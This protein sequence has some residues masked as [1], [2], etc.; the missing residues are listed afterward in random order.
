M[1]NP[2][3]YYQVYL[4]FHC[5]QAYQVILFSNP[6]YLVNNKL[7]EGD[8]EYDSNVRSDY[9]NLFAERM[10]QNEAFKNMKT[11]EID[12]CI[13]NSEAKCIIYQDESLYETSKS[14]N[15]KSIIK[16]ELIS[17]TAFNVACTNS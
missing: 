14:K 17:L 12:F 8:K 4:N 10:K 2:T 11:E 13:T 1:V 16:N 5:N 15:A 6:F 7:N 3:E 9:D